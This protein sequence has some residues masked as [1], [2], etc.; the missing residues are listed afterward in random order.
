MSTVSSSQP[1]FARP[2]A[3]ESC[4]WWQGPLKP[5]FESSRQKCRH[6]NHTAPLFGSIE[7]WCGPGKCKG[8]YD[9]CFSASAA[10]GYRRRCAPRPRPPTPHVDQEARCA[11]AIS[12]LGRYGAL[13]SG[14]RQP[15]RPPP[16]TRASVVAR[17]CLAERICPRVP[18]LWVGRAHLLLVRHHLWNRQ[19][20][21]EKATRT[22][23]C[24]ERRESE[25]MTRSFAP[26]WLI[27]H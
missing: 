9:A 14:R 3:R 25:R 6:S 26:G 1:H 18:P 13:Q 21:R 8:Q 11:R 7:N 4:P 23:R 27:L 16:H 5:S 24:D 20:Q 22:R 12:P 15:C 19:R 17:A 2:G 10:R